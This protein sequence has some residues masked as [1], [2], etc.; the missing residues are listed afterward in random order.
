MADKT[1][2]QFTTINAAADEL[3]VSR[4]FIRRRIADGTLKAWR[5]KGSPVIRILRTDVLKL[6]VGV[7]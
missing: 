6:L 1:P 5:L 4:M 7:K 3:G 2:S